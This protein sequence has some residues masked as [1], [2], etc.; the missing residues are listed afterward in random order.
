M[1]AEPS[2]ARYIFTHFTS[3]FR[4]IFKKEDDIILNFLEDDGTKIE[5]NFYL[6]II[7]TI[8]VNGSRGMGT[9]FAC[10]ILGYNPK[11]IKKYILNLLKDKKQNV[12][13][14][15]WYRNFNGTVVKT[16]EGQ[17]VFTGKLK[18]VNS[19][20]IEISE[21]PIGIYLD[22]YKEILNKLEDGGLIKDYDDYSTEKEFKFVVNCPRSTTYLSEDALYKKFKLISRETE[23]F[24]V[25]IP[26]DKLKKFYSAEELCDYFVL[27]R[28]EKYEE[29][30]IKLIQILNEN[31]NWLNEKLRFILFYIKNSDEFSKKKKDELRQMLEKEKFI[32]IDDLLDIRIYNLTY[33]QIEKLKNEIKNVEIQ[34]NSLN[35][36]N[37][38]EM[39][40][41]ELEELEV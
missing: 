16:D 3:D 32:N 29:R 27:F 11:D 18:V 7:P 30:R 19:T 1:S 28:L 23:N 40:I 24:T 17:I 14:I 13:L 35:N 5:P 34:I 38:L 41:N 31:L 10:N 39:Y 20:T 4:K 22:D 8:L 2:A 15:P 36:T 12:K 6:P 26:N 33:E 9:G 37:N 21:L 25:W